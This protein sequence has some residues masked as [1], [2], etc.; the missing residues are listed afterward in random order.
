VCGFLSCFGSRNNNSLGLKNIKHRG[1]DNTGVWRSSSGEYP[2]FLGHVRLSI[3]DTQDQSNQPMTFDSRYHFVYNGEIYNYPELRE[4]LISNGV[5]FK[6]HSDSEVLFK[7]IIKEG[8]SFLLR[9]NGMWSFCLYDSLKQTVF[10]CRDRFGIKPLYY[11]FDD[12]NN[13][14]CSSEMKALYPF[15]SLEFS[16][17][18]DR[19]LSFIFDNEHCES[20]VFKK[21]KKL[22][23]GTY[24]EFNCIN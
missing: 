15:V 6:T 18:I 9:C 17:D 12:K 16:N 3:I 14:Y 20:T 10:L 2:V 8:P 24:A 23:P 5:F 4:H 22:L 19:R 11:M 13:F 21:I 1:P 7:G